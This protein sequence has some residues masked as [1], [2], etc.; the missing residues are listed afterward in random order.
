M[1]KKKKNVKLKK[2]WNE[3]NFGPNDLT[4]PNRP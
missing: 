2:K 3:A 1:K 4:H